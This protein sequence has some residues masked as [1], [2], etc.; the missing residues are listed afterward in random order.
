MEL[1]G[2]VGGVGGRFDAI[3]NLTDKQKS[4]FRVAFKRHD[5]SAI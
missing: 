1:V 5:A 4:H 2:G 3:Q